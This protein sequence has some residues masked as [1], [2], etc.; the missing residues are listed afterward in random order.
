MGREGYVFI[1]K[2][3]GEIA[4]LPSQWRK[5]AFCHLEAR[6]PHE[7]KAQR[8]RN[9]CLCVKVSSRPRNDGKNSSQC[10]NG[11]AVS[12]KPAK[13]TKREPPAK[14]II[15]MLRPLRGRD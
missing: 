3:C 14:P 12:S 15:C 2:S 13:G 7:R 9:P 1:L 4:S 11:Y 5:R 8:L 6:T 10:Q